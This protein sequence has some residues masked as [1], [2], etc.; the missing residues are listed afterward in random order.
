MSTS[1]YEWNKTSLYLIKC[2]LLRNG[3]VR[4]H[5]RPTHAKDPVE[6]CLEAMKYTNKL[7][8]SDQ[9]FFTIIGKRDY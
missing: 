5:V 1:S 4:S 6:A 7:Q 9:L 8:Q 3:T 2:T